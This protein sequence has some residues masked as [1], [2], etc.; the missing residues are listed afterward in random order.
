MKNKCFAKKRYKSYDEEYSH[1]VFGE[2]GLKIPAI[3]NYVLSGTLP[4]S[5]CLSTPSKQ[6]HCDELF[7]A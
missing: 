7:E 1:F 3:E 5:E 4:G 2:D 6:T